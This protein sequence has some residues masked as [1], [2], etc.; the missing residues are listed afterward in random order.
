MAED[1]AKAQARRKRWSDSN[2]EKARECSR[3]G[4]AKWKQAHPEKVKEDAAR[5]ARE[6]PERNAAHSRASYAR[7][8]ETDP[9]EAWARTAIAAAKQRAKR[10]GVPFTLTAQDIPRPDICEVL[11]LSLFYERRGLKCPDAHSPTVDRLVPELGYVLG[12]I[13]VISHRANA[14][15]SNASLQELELVLAYMRLHLEN[16]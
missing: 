11:G 8:F 3:R 13:R 12:N 15:K 2:P 16:K 6:N 9:K 4:S 1:P 14:L 10:S 5:W 7:L